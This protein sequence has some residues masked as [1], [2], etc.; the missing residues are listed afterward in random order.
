M[1][2]PD[3]QI[4]D[5]EL[6][7]LNTPPA[8]D[9]E[10]TEDIIL[11]VAEDA[12]FPEVEETEVTEQNYESFLPPDDDPHPVLELDNDGRLRPEEQTAYDEKPPEPQEGFE[13]GE[14]I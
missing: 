4:T 6:A 14:G 7:E 1:S 12:D 11:D 8:E 13:E 9:D 5:D 10:A 3:F 2:V